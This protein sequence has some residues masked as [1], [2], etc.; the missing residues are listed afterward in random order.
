M[1]LVLGFDT[2]TTG[3]DTKKDYIL[4]VGA[5]IYDTEEKQIVEVMDKF[6]TWPQAPHIPIEVKEIHGISQEL[7]KKWGVYPEIVFDQLFEMASK[8]DYV[9]GHNALMFDK[10]ILE[11]ALMRIDDPNKKLLQKFYNLKWIDT[12]CDVPYPNHI[13]V[14]KL[15]YLAFHHKYIHQQAHRA[16][17]DVFACLHLLSSYDFDLIQ[18]I[19]KTALVT[20]QADLPY[21]RR[22]EASLAGFYWNKPNKKWEK[23]IK[24][25]WLNDTIRQLKFPVAISQEKFPALEKAVSPLSFPTNYGQTKLI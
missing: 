16:L 3:V 7:I 23:S 5:A 10:P 20:L 6:L 22:E 11:T 1:A 13:K 25:Y 12:I 2:E 19:S 21:E 8:C 9:C 14:R 4:E 15:E 17:F 18:A 24:E